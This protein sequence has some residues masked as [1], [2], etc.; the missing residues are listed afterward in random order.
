M[1]WWLQLQAIQASFS[2]HAAISLPQIVK[3]SNKVICQKV[4]LQESLLVN[5]QLMF[6]LGGGARSIPKFPLSLGIGGPNLT[7]CVI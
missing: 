5:L 7:Q 3:T 1:D 6:W 2:Q 4:I